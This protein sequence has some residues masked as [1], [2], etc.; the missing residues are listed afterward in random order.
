MRL[1]AMNDPRQNACDEAR[2]IADNGFDFLD[3]TIEGPGATVE[4]IDT[5][6]LRAILDGGGLGIVGHT[7]WYLPFASPIARVRQAAVDSTVDTLETFAT[8]GVPWV[9]VHIGRGI[10]A[11][12]HEDILRWNC[13]SFAQLAERATAYNL[14]IMVEHVPDHDLRISDLRAMLNADARLGFHLDVGHAFVGGDKLEGLL[15]AFKKR[16]VHVHLSDNWYRTDDHLPLGAGR[17]EWPRAIQLI[18]ETGYDD[19]ITLE[20][21]SPDRDYL[22]FS[23]QKVRGWWQSVEQALSGEEEEV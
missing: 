23:A 9:T 21:F 4:Q 20:V 1:G 8:L 5:A 22:L 14:G 10:K 11:F 15:K 17:I 2:W 16:L 6:E 18:K 19:T 12:D 7:A 3:L 13:E